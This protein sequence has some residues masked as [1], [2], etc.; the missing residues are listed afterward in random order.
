MRS[1]GWSGLH[2][3]RCSRRSR[4]RRSHAPHSSEFLRRLGG[5]SQSP[6]ALREESLGARA[7]IRGQCF[8]AEFQCSFTFV[9]VVRRGGADGRREYGGG[10]R[11]RRIGGRGSEGGLTAADSDSNRTEL[12]VTHTHTP[13]PSHRDNRLEPITSAAAGRR[14]TETPHD[15]SRRTIVADY[16]VVHT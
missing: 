3:R 11:G 6:H 7:V 8:T 10:S 2:V 16:D 1:G 9:G 4:C 15:D 5:R 13:Q 14:R 12:P